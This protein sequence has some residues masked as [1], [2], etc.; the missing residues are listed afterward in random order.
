LQKHDTNKTDIF[1]W[2]TRFFV[3]EINNKKY[4]MDKSNMQ[5]YPIRDKK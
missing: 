5:A 1:E 2:E 3:E 4:L